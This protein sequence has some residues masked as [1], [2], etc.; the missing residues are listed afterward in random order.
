MLQ[1]NIAIFKVVTGWIL[2]NQ[3][4]HVAWNDIVVICSDNGQEWG[5]HISSLLDTPADSAATG[6]ASSSYTPA[7]GDIT[8]RAYR[9]KSGETGELGRSDCA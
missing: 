8:G 3:A 1:C 7:P 9:L 2:S 4:C 5:S 6:G